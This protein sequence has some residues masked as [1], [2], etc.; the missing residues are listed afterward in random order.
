MVRRQGGR[1]GVGA[2]KKED[3]KELV[4]EYDEEVDALYVHIQEGKHHKT[5]EIDPQVYVDLD[6]E[7]KQLGYEFLS[8]DSFM[9]HIKAIL[10]SSPYGVSG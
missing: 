9:S 6:A 10:E 7:G 3:M 5:I 4:I 1:V 2:G 8:M